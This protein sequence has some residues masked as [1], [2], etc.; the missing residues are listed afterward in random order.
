MLR[1]TVLTTISL[2]VYTLLTSGQVGSKLSA[3]ASQAA[4]TVTLSASPA[5]IPNGE[6][7]TLAWTSANATACSG[8]GK[9]FSPSGPSGSLA[10]SPGV[11]T[12]YGVTCT[13]AGGSASQSVAVTV[14]AAPTLAIGMTVAATGT[15]LRLVNAIDGYA[16]NRRRGAGKPGRGHRRSSERQLVDMVEGGL[17]RRPYRMDFPERLSRPH[18]QRRRHS[19]SARIPRASPPAPRRRFHGRR[20]TRPPATEQAS[21]HRASQDLSQS[22]RL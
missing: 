20:P 8:T 12:T 5:S 2:L 17:Q 21:L 7:S 18:R 9:G 1:R 11:T 16:R 14:T 6:S 13:G 3:Q 4:A 19:R 15:D 10:V 22:R